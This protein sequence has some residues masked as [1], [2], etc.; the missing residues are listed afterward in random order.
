M[1]VEM[2]KY[3]AFNGNWDLKDFQVADIS[4]F[5]KASGPAVNS[6]DP[7]L[8]AYFGRNGKLLMYHGWADPG[9]PPMGTVDYFHNVTKQV[10]EKK[11]KDDMRLFM[12]PGMG[13]CGGGDGTSTFTMISA[14]EQWVE[15]GKAPET[16]AASRM[17]DGKVDRTRPLCAFPKVAVYS[18]SGSADDAANFSCK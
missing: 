9:V 2:Y 13:H 4:K 7:N 12:V 16:I 15:Q 3:A 18:G 10:G 17:R 6:V 8:N 11:A 5:E 1:A 14:M